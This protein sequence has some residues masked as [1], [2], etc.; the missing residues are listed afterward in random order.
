MFGFCI[1]YV[2]FCSS[3]L[4]QEER[5]LL[6][7]AVSKTYEIYIKNEELFTKN[8]EFINMMNFA[9]VAAGVPATTRY[10]GRRHRGGGAAERRAVGRAG[11]H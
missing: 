4:T 6:G 8:E 10:P 2:E 7:A 1:E 3:T 11:L 5:V 9:G